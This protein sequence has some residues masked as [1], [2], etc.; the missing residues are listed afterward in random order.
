VSLAVLLKLQR[1]SNLFGGANQQSEPEDDFRLAFFVGSTSVALIRS[2]IQ[3]SHLVCDLL[4]AVTVQLTVPRAGRV[5]SVDGISM[6]VGIFIEA[7]GITIIS[8]E[9]VKLVETACRRIVPSGT[10]ILLGNINIEALTAVQQARQRNG[11]IGKL[12]IATADEFGR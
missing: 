9:R 10:E 7:L 5:N 4:R 11:F 12:T 2:A 8:G 3:Q 6:H 1:E